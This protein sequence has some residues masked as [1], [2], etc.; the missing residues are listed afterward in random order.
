M[1]ASTL[2]LA[3]LLALTLGKPL[4]RRAMIVHETQVLPEGFTSRGAA[5][6]DTM[7]NLR[8]ALAQTNPDGLVQ[9]LMD[10]ST[11]GNALYGQHLTKEEV[12]TR[13]QIH[14]PC[15]Y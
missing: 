4:T 1:V 6:P 8:L 9:S 5:S 11:P 13:F 14:V 15:K 7:L 10:V 2:F 12:R 3:S